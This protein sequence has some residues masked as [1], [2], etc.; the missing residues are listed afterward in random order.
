MFDRLTSW[1]TRKQRENLGTEETV[2]EL[3]VRVREIK[4]NARRQRVSELRMAEV[5]RV[6]PV[7]DR[8]KG[9]TQ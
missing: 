9:R 7:Y 2:R 6:N 4:N 8:L 1:I 5:S 3:S